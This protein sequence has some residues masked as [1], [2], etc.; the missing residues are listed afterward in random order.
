[1]ER[2]VKRSKEGQYTSL[3]DLN[4]NIFHEIFQ[5]VPYK[6]LHLHVR[7]TSKILRSLVESYIQLDKSFLLYSTTKRDFYSK[8][9]CPSLASDGHYLVKTLSALKRRGKL[10]SILPKLSH[11]IPYPS[12]LGP[13][14]DDYTFFENINGKLIFGQVKFT[15]VSQSG[16]APLETR[17]L[18]KE[19]SDSNEYNTFIRLFEYKDY[20]NNWHQMTPT[21]PQPKHHIYAK[22]ASIVNLNWCVVE[23]VLFLTMT[24]EIQNHGVKDDPSYHGNPGYNHRLIWIQFSE[25]SVEIR[26][27][28][29]Y[30]SFSKTK[31]SVNTFDLFSLAPYLRKNWMALKASSNEILLL[32]MPEHESGSSRLWR[33]TMNKQLFSISWKP[34]YITLPH[35]YI[36]NSNFSSS[37]F[38]LGGNIYVIENVRYSPPDDQGMVSCFVGGRINIQEEKYYA[39]EFWSPTRIVNIISSTPDK[40]EKFSIILCEV[41]DEKREY[42]GQTPFRKSFY[43]RQLMFFDDESGFLHPMNNKKLDHSFIDLTID[44]CLY[45]KLIR[46]G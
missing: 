42:R 27:D 1:M 30:K 44:C 26:G 18:D 40:N 39:F 28:K 20:K 2:D 37:V 22:N 4:E 25:P 32:G 15:K 21:D 31:Y 38:Q 7:N 11:N 13:M 33:G 36:K 17:V 45:D 10:V 24:I 35:V 14:T 12:L 29:G 8:C 46:I 23:D 6:D 19:D 9:L 43:K 34:I 3:M 16:K 5:Y 41:L